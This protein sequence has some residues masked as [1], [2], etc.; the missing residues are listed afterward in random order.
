MKKYYFLIP[1][2]AVIVINAYFR[3]QTA[4][5]PFVKTNA[6]AAVEK[7]FY[8]EAKK[9]VDTDFPQVSPILKPSLADEIFTR[10]QKERKADIQKKIQEKEKELRAQYTDENGTVFLFELDPYHW[11]RLVRNVVTFGRVAEARV[12]KKEIDP[13]MLAP[14]GMEAKVSLHK[15][16]HVYIAAGVYKFLQVF[17]RN[18]ELM[19]TVFFMPVLIAVLAVIAVFCM[20]RYCTGGSIAGYFAGLT[21]GLAPI[22]LMRSVGGWF[23]TDPYIFLFSVL[24][25]W[26]YYACIK[27][28]STTIKRVALAFLVSIGTALFA[29]T[30]D[31]WWYIFDLVVFASAYYLLNLFLLRNECDLKNLIKK[32]SIALGTYVVF[33][34]FLVGLLCGKEVMLRFIQGP[35]ETFSV[36]Y[37]DTFWPNTF[38]TVA[39]LGIGNPREI[40]M[41]IGGPMV[42]I[43]GIGYLLYTLAD[44]R[45]SDFLEKGFLGLFFS[46][47]LIALYLV[48]LKARRFSLLLAVP[49]CIS[50]GFF[51]D[52]V[53]RFFDGTGSAFIRSRLHRIL[54]FMGLAGAITYTFIHASIPAKNFMPM[55]TRQWWDALTEIKQGTP[56]N[57]IVNSWWDYGHWYKAIAQRRVIFDGATQNTP[58]AY[59]MGRVLT[60]ADEKEAVGILRMINSGSN[61]A[62]ETLESTG[63]KKPQ[64]ITILYELFPLSRN[65]ADAHLKKYG[66]D[67]KK[68]QEILKYMYEPAPAYM[69]VESSLLFKI[70]PIS[71]LGNWDFRRADIYA[72]FKRHKKDEFLAYVMKTYNYSKEGALGMYGML[73]LL[74]KEDALNWVSN[75]SVYYSDTK[76]VKKEEGVLYFE[77]GFA[78]NLKDMSVNGYNSRAGKWQVP[79]SIFYF[80][81]GELKERVFEKNDGDYSVLLIQ[82]DDTYRLVVLDK[83]L[84]N[85]LL[86]RLFYLKG[87]GLSHFKL[88]LEKEKEGQD[89]IFVYQ[90]LWNEQ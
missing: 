52:T 15:N 42:L 70:K 13:Y 61:K 21:L 76:N 2:F 27:E 60:T 53:Y 83:N 32:T 17:N 5:T 57:A 39:E 22:F 89:S 85:S 56:A 69:I 87:K 28:N 8:E 26:G 18:L 25:T 20:C 7:D 34:L 55:I 38:L 79:K 3:V 35:W 58:F 71:F 11:F 37:K 73:A 44:K 43:F 46:F 80:D 36:V 54:L 4:G 88:F 77:N 86:V 30:W 84:V 64:C 29:F 78:V 31:G 12:G 90:I 62:F 24:I 16:L 14:Q 41:A 75:P 48:S 82:E 66:I 9:Q 63:I 33:S 50:F 23:D 59:W 19:R 47:W 68:R 1:L 72:A 65:E 74:S 40:V 49:V 45:S 67:E 51:M 10:W 81:K 6:R